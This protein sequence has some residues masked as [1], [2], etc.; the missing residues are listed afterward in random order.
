MTNLEALRYEKGL[1]QKELAEMMGADSS[2]IS[3]LESGAWKPTR[4]SRMQFKLE[5]IFQKPM[6]WLLQEA[7]FIKD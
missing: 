3:K 7:I 4:M 1:Q 2:L 5:E 6:K